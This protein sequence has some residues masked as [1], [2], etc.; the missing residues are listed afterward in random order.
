MSNKSIAQKMMIKEGRKVL[1]VNAPKGYKQKLGPLPAGATIVTRPGEPAD[2]IQVFVANRR[3]L[4]EQLPKLKA[5]LA[6]DGML[7]VAYLK[8]TSQTRT[9]INRDSLHAYARTAGLEGVSLI[10]VDDDWSAMRF[11]VIGG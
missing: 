7:W 4:E 3:E 11:K 8:G 10:S 9:D 5:A 2:V 6:P 1:L